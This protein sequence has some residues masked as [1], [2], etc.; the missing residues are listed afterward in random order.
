VTLHLPMEID[1]LGRLGMVLDEIWPGC[2]LRPLPSGDIEV[3][4]RHPALKADRTDVV[5]LPL[6][7]TVTVVTPPASPATTRAATDDT[8][9]VCDAFGFGYR[10]TLRAG[11]RGPHAKLTDKH[12]LIGAWEQDHG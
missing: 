7:G 1:K 2:T 5:N 10:C 4:T 11:H 8:T 3:I 12:E 9:P 6:G